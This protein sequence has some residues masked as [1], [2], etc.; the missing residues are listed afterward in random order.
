L[1]GFR[2]HLPRATDADGFVGTTVATLRLR[3]PNDLVAPVIAFDSRVPGT[4]ISAASDI[5]GKVSGTN[6]DRWSLE[7]AHYGSETYTLR[8]GRR[9]SRAPRSSTHATM[10][11]LNRLARGHDIRLLSP[12]SAAASSVA[13][14]A[15]RCPRAYKPF[16]PTR[17]SD[18]TRRSPSERYSYAAGQS[19]PLCSN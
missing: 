7:I 1:G 12:R 13:D 16:A 6:L 14:S 18:Y 15:S 4:R 19:S 11:G 9:L 10:K 8:R 17:V 2:A 5:L 3:D